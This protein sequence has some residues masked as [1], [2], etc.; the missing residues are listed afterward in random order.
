MLLRL[1]ADIIMFI[2][3]IGLATMLFSSV[4]FLRDSG[5]IYSNK[6]K[7][8][9]SNEVVVFRSIGD[10][11]QTILRSYAGIAALITYIS[12]VYD[13]I[14][15]F[16]SNYGAPNNIFNIPFLILWLGL[17]LHL[18]ISLIPTLIIND[19]LK[20][21]RINYIRK[22][23]NKMGIEDTAIISFEFKKR[24]G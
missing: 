9:N 6:K 19:L 13:F 4:W 20:K 2:L 17:P 15:R 23:S 22:I 16:I 24:N 10:W 14:T 12:V 8:E 1:F 7:L 18:S 11:Y 3:T 21:R 5:I